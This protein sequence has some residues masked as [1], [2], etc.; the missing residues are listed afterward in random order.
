MVLVRRFTGLVVLVQD[1]KEIDY[2]EKL[3]HTSRGL[4]FNLVHEFGIGCVMWDI[5]VLPFLITREGAV[6]RMMGDII[7]LR[8]GLGLG[9]SMGLCR[10]T[11]PEMHAFFEISS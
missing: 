4:W 11:S 7:L 9:N 3:M 8:S 2:T 10:P 1:G 6:I 5:P